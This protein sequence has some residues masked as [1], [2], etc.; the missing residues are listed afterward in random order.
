[1]DPEFGS[2]TLKATR[3]AFQ[4]HQRPLGDGGRNFRAFEYQ[5]LDGLGIPSHRMFDIQHCM[6]R[7]IVPVTG[8]DAQP[9]QAR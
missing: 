1:L 8:S 3:P 4:P 9:F 7:K 6:K 5:R 2:V